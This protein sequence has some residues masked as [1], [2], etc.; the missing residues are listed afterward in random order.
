MK[1]RVLS[2]SLALVALATMDA[3]AATPVD[4]AIT[5]SIGPLGFRFLTTGHTA[6]TTMGFNN[7]NGTPWNCGSSSTLSLDRTHDAYE[8]IHKV[9]LA[10]VL[11]GRTVTV[12]YE[13]IGT[14]C[15]VKRLGL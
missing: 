5:A 2:L 14:T 6:T 9:A 15:W 12:Y 1:I 8:D 10:A 7:S 11:A 3:R 13:L 4:N